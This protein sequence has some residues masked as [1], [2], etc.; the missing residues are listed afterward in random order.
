MP[1][2][3]CECRE[4]GREDEGEDEDYS[5]GIRARSDGSLDGES[6][7]QPD[8]NHEQGQD[9]CGDDHCDASGYAA[10][11]VVVDVFVIGLVSC[12]LSKEI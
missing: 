9:D 8:R 1:F 11:V 12:F 3:L 2:R 10:S 5:D 6:V 4:G 7:K